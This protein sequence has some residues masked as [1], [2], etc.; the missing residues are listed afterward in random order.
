MPFDYPALQAELLA[1]HPVT[2]AYNIDDQLAANELNALNRPSE[3]EAAEILQYCL[4]ETSRTNAG[5]DLVASNIYGRIKAVA[6]SAVGADPFNTGRPGDQLKL[7][8]IHAAE[9]MLR[10]LGAE[11]GFALSL[12]D[13][14]FD[15]IL[16]Q[17]AQCRAMKQGDKTAIQGLSVDQQNR[18]MEL[19]LGRNRVNADHVTKA[20]AL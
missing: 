17:L 11:S 13:A 9:A 15:A 19:Q 8:E 4:L 2:G 1:G 10:I 18:V 16:E 6:G 7:E 20:R 5:A 14:R 3:A 12:L